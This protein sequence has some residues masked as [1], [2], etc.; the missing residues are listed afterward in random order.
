ME[1]DLVDRLP[2][3]LVL[4][5]GVKLV[6]EVLN[7]SFDVRDLTLGDGCSETRDLSLLIMNRI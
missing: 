5:K 7:H 1:V 6:A 2:I 4:E 3:L